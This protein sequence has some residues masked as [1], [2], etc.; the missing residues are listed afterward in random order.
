[1][2]QPSASTIRYRMVHRKHGV[3]HQRTW[4]RHPSPNDDGQ[5]PWRSTIYIREALIVMVFEHPKETRVASS[6]VSIRLLEEFDMVLEINRRPLDE[7]RLV[8]MLADY[9]NTQ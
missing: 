1:M 2:K 8:G 4:L 3:E 6:G 5:L 7:V 9:A